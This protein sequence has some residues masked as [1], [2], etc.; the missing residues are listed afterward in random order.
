MMMAGRLHL[1][2][3]TFAALAACALSPSFSAADPS[4]YPEYV[5]QK[6]P[7]EIKAEFISVDELVADIKAG[8]KP[9]IIDVRSA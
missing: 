8:K 9:V 2:L 1:F 3:L 4:K 5:Q 6:L 7:D